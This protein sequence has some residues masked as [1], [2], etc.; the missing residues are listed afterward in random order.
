MKV[1]FIGRIKETPS[2]RLSVT[3][4]PFKVGKVYNVIDIIRYSSFPDTYT[5]RLPDYN[6]YEDIT[7]FK[8]VKQ[9][10]QRQ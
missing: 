1:R 10:M 3:Y 9:R 4:C 6:Y 8:Q 5:I 2:Y 7:S